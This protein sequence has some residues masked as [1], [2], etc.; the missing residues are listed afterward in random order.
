MKPRILLARGLPFALVVAVLSACAEKPEGL[1]KSAKDYLAKGDQKGAAV[2]LRSALQQNPDLPE[3][4]YLLG[5]ALLET[6]DYPGSEKELRNALALGYPA[7]QVVPTLVRAM[8]AAGQFKEAVAE[9]GASSIDAPQGR[10][11]LKSA[12]GEAYFALGD[13]E[14]GK[15][16]FEAALV[17]QP[18]YP[19]AIV[20]G[21]NLK[22]ANGDIAGAVAMIDAALAKSPKFAE[23]WAFKGDLA[24]AQGQRAEAMEAY[25]KAIDLRPDL[26]GVHSRMVTILVDDGKAEEAA[27]QVAAMKRIAPAHPQTLYLEA[28]LAYRRKD[29]AAARDALQQNLR[30][31]PGNL[32]G[33]LLAG[34]VDYELKSYATAETNLS[35]VLS[36]VPNHPFARRVLIRSYLQS[37]QP[38]KALEAIKP[39]L[40][41]VEKDPALMALAGEVFL[42]NGQSA[43]AVKYF[44][45]SVALDPKS[46]DALLGLG[47][48]HLAMGKNDAA[49]HELETAASE[50]PEINADVILIRSALSRREFDKAL[51]AVDAMEKKRPNTP[52]GRNLRGV[53]LLGKRDIAGARKS[54]EQAVALDAAYFP[55]ASNL[56]VLDLAG[57]KPENAKK[58]FEAVLAKNP[59]SGPALLAL[60]ELRAREGAPAD[61]VAAM[62]DK[63][64]ATDP[65]AVPP[66]EKLIEH[67]I[68]ANDGKKAVAAA[69]N[70]VTALP[71][72]PELL[73]ALGRAQLAAGETN[74]ALA[75]FK[76]LLQLQPNATGPLLRLSAAQVIAKD[77]DG[78]LES[79]RKALKLQPNLID[80]QR[81]IVALE[82]EAG[83]V[84]QAVAVA[85]EVQKQRPNE[86]IG[87]LLEGD[88]YSI[89]KSSNE[90]LAAYR[91]ALKHGSSVDA[92]MKLHA[93]LFKAGKGAEADAMATAWLKEHP[94]ETAF[95]VYLAQSA[96]EQGNYAV[97]ARHYRAIVDEQ[98][99][100][101]MQL[102]N[103]AWAAGRA[104]DPKAIEYAEKAYKLAPDEAG[105]LDTLGTLLVEK[106]DKAR[107]LELLQKASKLAPQSASTRL[108]LAKALISNGQGDAAKKELEQLAR[109]GDKFGQQSEVSQLM[110]GL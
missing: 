11:E 73:D 32:Q 63:A 59:N 66:R 91:Q 78:A 4:R 19:P 41:G 88:V 61:E 102:N 90:A 75:S 100:N 44:T 85:R 17:A 46:S 38:G 48:A 81:A 83:R 55:A 22:A 95:R 23:G 104:K 9:F 27:A 10:A 92:A 6:R 101:A 31:A 18:D 71:N 15:A 42:Q 30:A 69:Q 36:A 94:K 13:R 67:W 25:R 14:A 45:R 58:R 106:G 107:G 24:M 86:S 97:A 51:A 103:L 7:D 98:P 65:A 35:T 40:S 37:G 105:V 57:N 99:N 84:P 56:A 82:V 108:N 70:A 1:V 29:Y 89:N 28:M 39:V 52:F 62:I 47:R 49:L 110:K 68:R 12:L 26:L 79:L 77:N 74:Q 80:A 5:S 2:Q 93:A 16:A 72:S 3:A 33:L 76:K 8:V 54:F 34:T 60:A 87:Y 20:G 64:I 96:L 43:E 21:A 53:V 50:S 109:M